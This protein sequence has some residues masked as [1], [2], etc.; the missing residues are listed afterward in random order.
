M[1]SKPVTVRMENLF[2]VG[3]K[4][5]FSRYGFLLFFLASAQYGM[6]S[7]ESAHDHGESAAAT[8]PGHASDAANEVGIQNIEGFKVKLEKLIEK[9]YSASQFFFCCDYIRFSFSASFCSFY[10]CVVPTRGCLFFE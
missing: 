1:A 6:A 10:T 2:Q 7:P 5:T 3:S 4:L 8:M 9:T